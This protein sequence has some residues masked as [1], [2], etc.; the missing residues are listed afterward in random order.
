MPQIIIFIHAEKLSRSPAHII[1]KTVFFHEYI[2]KAT[3]QVSCWDKSIL[4]GWSFCFL[5]WLFGLCECTCHQRNAF[6]PWWRPPMEQE[7]TWGPNEQWEGDRSGNSANQ[8][9]QF[10]SSVLIQSMPG[11]P[12]T[13]WWGV[14]V[15]AHLY[16]FSLKPQ[17]T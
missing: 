16:M 5:R 10:R 13:L 14:C 12:K 4:H 7:S 2:F 6:S 15:C 9:P 17:R 11:G 8:L 3:L 1:T